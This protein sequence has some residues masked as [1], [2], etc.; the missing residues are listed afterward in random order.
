MSINLGNLIS[1]IVDL[2]RTIATTLRDGFQPGADIPVWMA[3]W[4]DHEED[5]D[6]LFHGIDRE[7]VGN[8]SKAIGFDNVLRHKARQNNIT[9][10]SHQC[11]LIRETT[12]ARHKIAR[13]MLNE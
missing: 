11:N 7:D 4:R 3:W 13:D 2:A 1:L 9:L 10:R 12:V 6:D 8:D 5:I